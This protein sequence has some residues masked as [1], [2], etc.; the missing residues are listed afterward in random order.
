MNVIF[1]PT[2]WVQYTEWQKTDKSMVKKINDLIQDIQRNGFFTGIGKPEPLKKIA[3]IA[4]RTLKLINKKQVIL[5]P[6]KVRRITYFQLS[7]QT[8]AYQ[9]L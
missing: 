8:D 2:A 9:C 1:S 4:E 7:N 6:S 5:A 3:T